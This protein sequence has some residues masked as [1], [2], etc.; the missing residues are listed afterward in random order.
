M[1]YLMKVK[2]AV[3][4]CPQWREPRGDIAKHCLMS[5]KNRQAG[6]VGRKY[7]RLKMTKY[8]IFNLICK[9]P[10]FLQERSGGPE[11]KLSDAKSHLSCFGKQI[12]LSK[13]ICI[14]FV[15]CITASPFASLH[16][17]K[18]RQKV[19]QCL[20]LLGSSILRALLQTTVTLGPFL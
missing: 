5:C 11:I 8:I 9:S 1:N 13:M 19:E 4:A 12:M 20:K 2:V 18:K 7:K 17:N 15:F 16:Q 14:L 10:L 3:C 6:V